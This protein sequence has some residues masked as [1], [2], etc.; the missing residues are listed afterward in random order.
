MFGA[1][2]RW[3]GAYRRTDKSIGNVHWSDV[4]V[5]LHEALADA[6]AQLAAGAFPIDEV[7]MRLHH[8]LAQVHPFPNGN[9]RTAR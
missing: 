9:G 1:V 2:W 6:R 3:A 7:A 4:P 8:R 5:Q